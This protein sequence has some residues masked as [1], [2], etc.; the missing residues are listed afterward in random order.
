MHGVRSLALRDRLPATGTAARLEA[1]AAAGRLPSELAR[2]LR[3]SLQFL[4]GLK[5]NAGLA[6]LEHAAARSAA[7]CV[8]IG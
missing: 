7:A 2:E 6:E 4:M 5:L 8:P 1:L 3:D